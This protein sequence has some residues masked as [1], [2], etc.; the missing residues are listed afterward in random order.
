[1]IG[2]ICFL[3]FLFLMAIF[4][5]LHLCYRKKMSDYKVKNLLF[6]KEGILLLF[7]F[8]KKKKILPG[9]RERIEK[10]K[11]IYIG[12]SAD[13][14]CMLYYGNLLKKILLVSM[15][16]LL[17]ASLSSFIHQTDTFPGGYLVE[18]AGVGEAAKKLE[19]KADSG[20]DTKEIAL[21]IPARMLSKEEQKKKITA[22]KKK[23]E[24]SFLGENETADHIEKSFVFLKS[25]E[26]GSVTIQW[27]VSSDALYTEQG[28]LLNEELTEPKQVNL[29]AN[30]FCGESKDI[31]MKAVTIYPKIKTKLTFWEKWQKEYQKNEEQ[32]RE[33]TYIKLPEQIDGQV[34]TYRL[35]VISYPEL[36]FIGT[37]IL[38][39]LCPLLEESRLRTKLQKRQ[40]QLSIDYPEFVEHFVLLIGSGLD[41][42]GAWNR[43]IA[44][45]EKR[46]KRRKRH[47]VYDEMIVT[48]NEIENGMSEAQAYE[49][50]G[51]RTE[52]LAYMKFCTMIVQNLKKGSSDLLQLLEYEM[53]DSFHARKENAKAIGEKAGTKLLMPMAVMLLIVFA[54]ILYAAFQSM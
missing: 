8:L 14:I 1:M 33:K 27:E 7:I 39:L 42:K 52:L 50:F 26:S 17:L 25:A 44:E 51:K 3:L 53:T 32:S 20:T 6:L 29:K 10:L 16:G 23:I 30:L 54:L 48:M 34:M 4:A 31:W 21:E 2:E 35:K 36:F 40:E 37:C 45:Y 15:S 22:A 47:V 11:K 28:E 12:K 46:E 19:M 5:W 43:I 41:V 13:E 38:V 49:L 9:K 24:K 18:R